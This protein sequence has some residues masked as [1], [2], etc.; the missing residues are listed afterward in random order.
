MLEEGRKLYWKRVIP[1]TRSDISSRWESAGAFDSERS[2]SHGELNSREEKILSLENINGSMLQ[3]GLLINVT[4]KFNGALIFYVNLR[5]IIR[6]ILLVFYD[7]NND[8]YLIIISE[9]FGIDKY[10]FYI[11]LLS[12]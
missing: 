9:Y 4:L 6:D 2:V 1:A 7:I 11:I 3:N 12:V 5:C 10:S 8:N